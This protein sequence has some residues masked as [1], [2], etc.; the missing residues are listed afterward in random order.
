MRKR[1]YT[2]NESF[3]ETVDTAEKAYWLGFI[4]ADGCVYHSKR[5]NTF[6]L[7]LNL[8]SRDGEHLEKLRQALGSNSPIKDVMSRG[9]NRDGRDR[10]FPQKRI[11]FHSRKLAA[12]L[13]Q[14]GVYPRKSLTSKP[15]SAPATL[16]GHYWRGVIDGDGCWSLA[17]SGQWCL[18][19]TG[20]YAMVSGFSDFLVGLIGKP[21]RISSHGTYATAQLTGLEAI[22]EVARNLFR[23]DS[24]WLNR[25]KELVDQLLATELRK[26][27]W[28]WLTAAHLNDLYFVHKRWCFVADALGMDRGHISVVRLRLGMKTTRRDH[29][30]ITPEIILKSYQ[31]HQDWLKVGVELNVSN[32]HLWALRMR[33][34][35][36]KTHRFQQTK[37]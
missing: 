24:V 32:A 8:A 26:R 18:Q 33:L 19:L 35:M 20:T 1:I 17:A 15:W 25:K 21:A 9:F 10:K 11:V 16:A 22:K 3:F 12:D 5:D 34:G 30:W 36:P 13:A 23:G 28:A 31:R 37:A 7:V 27:S 29:S 2:L 6:A 14:C 4:T